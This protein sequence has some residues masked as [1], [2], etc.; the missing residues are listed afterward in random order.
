LATALGP[1]LYGLLHD[2]FGSY[3]PALIGAAALDVVAAVVVIAG[4]GKPAAL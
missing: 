4:R 2:A 1:S 3:N